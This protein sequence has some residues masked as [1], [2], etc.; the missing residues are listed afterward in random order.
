M[1]SVKLYPKQV[2][3]VVPSVYS[4]TIGARGSDECGCGQWN[5][6]HRRVEPSKEMAQASLSAIKANGPLNTPIAAAGL[7][8]SLFFGSGSR[9]ARLVQSSSSSLSSNASSVNSTVNVFP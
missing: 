9:S 1:G 5:A 8:A 6:A 3:S 4:L 7:F 2:A